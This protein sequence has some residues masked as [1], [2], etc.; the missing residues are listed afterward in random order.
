MLVVL[1][2]APGSGK[3]TL[4]RSLTQALGLIHFS[5]DAILE[6]KGGWSAS[7]W[8]EARKEVEA[9]LRPELRAVVDDDNHMTSLVKRLY[10]LAALHRLKFCHLILDTPLPMC[11]E[12]N[13]LRPNPIPENLVSKVH[14]VISD[15]RFLP[16]SIRLSLDTSFE[17][18]LLLVDQSRVVEAASEPDRSGSSDAK[19]QA[20]L[21]L[22]RLIHAL[23][24]NKLQ[25]KELQKL[26]KECLKVLQSAS[27][28]EAAELVSL[29]EARMLGLSNK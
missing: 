6:T 19:H 2:G 16:C 28:D 26:K 4:S 17:E 5:V 9:A 10:R 15:D 18:V 13:S 3:T 7:N 11:L 21:Q 27:E 29:T 1:T 8:H 14:Q 25:L 23:K 22:R 12:R 20:D 24:P